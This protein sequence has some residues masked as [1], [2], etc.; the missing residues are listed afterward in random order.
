MITAL[1]EKAADIILDDKYSEYLGFVYEAV[2]RNRCY[3]LGVEKV[4]PFI[5]KSTGKWWG[6]ICEDGEWKGTEADVIAYDDDN[7]VIGE[8]K[9]RKKA[10][11]MKE[12][13][14]L[15]LKA[16]FIPVKGRK[17]FYLLTGKSGFTKENRQDE[18]FRCCR[19][20]DRLYRGM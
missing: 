16:R 4:I 2:I 12:L 3:E 5:P 15:K 14:Y 18:E 8:C 10:I 9:Y 1:R 7:I 6:N 11:G 20:Y 13:D 17:V 19:L